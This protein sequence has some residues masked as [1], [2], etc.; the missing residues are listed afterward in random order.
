[1]TS[2][3]ATTLVLAA[4]SACSFSP[5]A[6]PAAPPDAGGIGISP[7]GPTPPDGV[8]LV[9]TAD[10]AGIAGAPVYFLN[11]DS[12][13]AAAV[14]T[15]ATGTAG[16]T[17][18]DGGSVTVLL[19]AAADGHAED[20][21]D[22][23]YTFAGVHAR[24]VLHVDLRP[25]PAGSAAA[26]VAY[27]TTLAT[28]APSAASY[29]VSSPCSDE[30][31][32][33][34]GTGAGAL[35]LVGCGTSSDLVVVAQDATGAPLG[36]ATIVA[37][38]LA[39]PGGGAGG[40][41]PSAPLALAPSFA[42]LA[43]ATV[44]I[45]GATG[46]FASAAATV[47]VLDASGRAFFESSAV[48]P[49]AGAAA[50]ITAPVAAPVSAGALALVDAT[51]SPAP[52]ATAGQQL[53]ATWGPAA[54]SYAIDASPALLPE[55]A[56]APTFAGDTL[57][58]T[59]SAAG[60]GTASADLVRAELD[61][62]RAAI[63]DGHSWAWHVVAPRGTAPALALPALPF[64]GHFDYNPAAADS[65][66]IPELTEA[67]VPGGYDAAR[68]AGFGDLARIAQPAT[69]GSLTVETLAVPTL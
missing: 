32:S 21:V 25:A 46:A 31:G 17:V 45:T 16:A 62:T 18:A 49:I 34:D 50:T 59:E 52:A 67:R 61:L 64:D 58:W 51:L 30:P 8:A 39:D 23:L 37:Q 22:R 19:R 69:P 14:A 29:L 5:P 4:L 42:P 41:F 55:L 54:A 20:G 6:P 13:V 43:T 24:D 48:Q 10:G 35:V 53:V 2:R 36:A 12:S 15:D 28:V 40:A 63:P 65:V 9:V 44:T 26:G 1:M 66:A 60:A 7:P 33:L 47:G 56:A 68:A 3:A 57:A 27:A 38:P 11:A